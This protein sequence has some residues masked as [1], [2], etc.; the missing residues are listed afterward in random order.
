MTLL[1]YSIIWSITTKIS[2]Q[3]LHLKYSC[4]MTSKS[5]LAFRRS[6]HSSDMY[7]TT[8]CLKMAVFSS[9]SSISSFCSFLHTRVQCVQGNRNLIP[10]EQ[11]QE[12]VSFNAVVKYIASKMLRVAMAMIYGM[13]ASYAGFAIHLPSSF[14]CGL[15]L[16]IV[17]STGPRADHS[18]NGTTQRLP[19]FIQAFIIAMSLQIRP[20]LRRDFFWGAALE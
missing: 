4:S 15:C 11:I 2:S 16:Y 6:L 13:S 5:V 1:S 9:A 8:S 20:H 10:E 19:T 14:S 3:L 7:C 12:R 18:N 17:G